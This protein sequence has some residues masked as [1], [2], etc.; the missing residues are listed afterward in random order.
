MKRWVPL[1]DNSSE[2]F[3]STDLWDIDILSVHPNGTIF[4]RQRLLRKLADYKYTSREKSILIAATAIGALLTILPISYSIQHY[5][6]RKTFAVVMIISGLSTALCPLAA[7]FGIIYLIISRILQG[8]GFASCMPII[9]SV[10]AT[11]AKLTENGL[12]SGALTSFIQK[13]RCILR[14]IVKSFIL[15]RQMEQDRELL[16]VVWPQCSV[17]PT[18]QN[19]Q[20]L[21][22]V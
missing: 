13:R 19:V 22:Q 8:I 1:V 2:W 4:Y 10:I 11:W 21:F 6:T 14:K 18:T 20:I 3:R 7:S 16:E 9:G 5:G 17:W 12:F 15:S